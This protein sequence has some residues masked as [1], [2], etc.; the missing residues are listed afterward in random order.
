M[1]VFTLTGVASASGSSCAKARRET[2]PAADAP[3]A[4]GAGDLMPKP[5]GS[6]P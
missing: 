5:L 6:R 3:R 2:E 1:G 4:I